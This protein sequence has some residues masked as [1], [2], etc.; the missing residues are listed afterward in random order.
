M[1]CGCTKNLGCFAYNDT[2]NFGLVAPIAGDYVFEI[3]SHGAFSTIT[4]TLALNDP[5]TLPFIYGEG[6]QT[7][8]K[9]KFPP[10]L[11]ATYPDGGVNY[12]T[13]TDG[14][15]CFVVTGVVQSCL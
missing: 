13:S 5:I 14:A 3:H 6:G 9:V 4:Q 8:I 10:A 15:C 2:I 11:I 7:L 1:N 12:M